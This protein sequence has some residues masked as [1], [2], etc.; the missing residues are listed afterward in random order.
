MLPASGRILDQTKRDRKLA[1][2]KP[3]A[4]QAASSS[5]ISGLLYGL[6]VASG[7]TLF[8]KNLP[9]PVLIDDYGPHWVDPS[10]EYL[11]L[12][13]GPDGFFWTYLRNVLVRI[14]PKDA[15]VDILERS[16]RLDIRHL[17]DAI[18][19]CPDPSNCD[20]SVTSWLRNNPV[21]LHWR[22]RCNPIKPSHALPH[23]LADML[24]RIAHVAARVGR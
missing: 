15:T 1:V 8:T 21:G 10:Y 4:D 6:D 17:S 19:I 12:V 20:E 5:S 7:A 13:P 18:F 11:G 16:L 3:D 23:T 24:A 2:A 22:N 14:D 9:W